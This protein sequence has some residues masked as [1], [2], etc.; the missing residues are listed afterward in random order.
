MATTGASAKDYTSGPILK[1]IVLFYLSSKNIHHFR[2]LL[3]CF[4][5]NMYQKNPSLP[6][7]PYMYMEISTSLEEEKT[8]EFFIFFI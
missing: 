5:M 4:K 3:F 6:N 1:N 2:C 8:R 7:V